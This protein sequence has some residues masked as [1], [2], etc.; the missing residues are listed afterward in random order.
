MN[1]IP[2]MTE[3]DKA[4][5]AG[6]REKGKDEMGIKKIARRFEAEIFE[7]R[8]S[9]ACIGTDGCYRREELLLG[10]HAFFR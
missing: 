10:A 1:V 4:L 7:V 6:F 8:C 5:V 9:C 2:L 3:E